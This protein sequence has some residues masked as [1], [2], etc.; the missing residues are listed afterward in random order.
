MVGVQRMVASS[1]DYGAGEDG[2]MSKGGRGGAGAE[3]GQT[4]LCPLIKQPF[5]PGLSHRPAHLEGPVRSF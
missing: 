2:L 3:N 5:T 1:Y 4:L